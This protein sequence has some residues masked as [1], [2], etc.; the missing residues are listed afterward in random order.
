[1]QSSLTSLDT[2]TISRHLEIK[3]FVKLAHTCERDFIT[4]Q[5]LGCGHRH[6]VATGS[7]DR[8]CP[9]CAQQLYRDLF[10]KYDP[11]ISSCKNLKFLTLT[12]KPVKN[13][14]P[15]IVRQLV[16]YFVKLMHR[17][18][19]S[20]IW[21]GI[22]AVIECKK[23]KSGMFYY[24]LHALLDGGFVPQ[25]QISEDW[26]SISSFPICWIASVQ[27]TPKRALRYVL[28]YILKGSALE[29]PQDK[30]DFKNSMYKT[31]FVHSYGSF[32]NSQYRSS[33]HVYYPCPN[34]GSLN[35]WVVLEFSNV[36]NLYLNEPYSPFRASVS[37]VSG[38]INV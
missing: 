7:K 28:K 1:M 35:C 26:C 21:K 20:V 37:P 27:R 34:C 4:I 24:H 10:E 23:T 18:P 38:D 36:V 22:L 12:F 15:E 29:L 19:Y 25:S 8:T 32:Y 16:S 5:C 14:S 31:R 6:S 30:L 2:N 13:Q 9:A 33:P 17:K 3:S 11:I